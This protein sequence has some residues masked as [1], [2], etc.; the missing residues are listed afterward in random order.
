MLGS[1]L[2]GLGTI[3][4][5]ATPVTTAS[6]FVVTLTGTGASPALPG[7]A[8]ATATADLSNFVFG[9][10]TV[11][12]TMDITN[13][14]SGPYLGDMRLTAIGWDT[15]PATSAVTDN[16][17]VY[18]S[19]ANVNLGPNSLSVCLYSGPNCDGGSN[20]G[21]EDPKN[22]GM[23]GDPTT[24]GN[25]S[26]TVT[27]GSSNVPPLDF[28]NFIGKF[29]TSNYSSF[30]APGTICTTNCGGGPGGGPIPEPASIALLG[31]GL[32]GLG[33]FRRRR[34]A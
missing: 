27:F 28:S 24:T 26:V 21:L 11:T 19:V 22:T 33:L 14:S 3:T 10:H 16:S 13:T 18:A 6:N 8:A 7:G 25:F 34:A 5:N 32:V 30:D 1:V 9:S 17:S 4:A 2:A 23:H 15:S 12:F 20:G 31:A 29:Q